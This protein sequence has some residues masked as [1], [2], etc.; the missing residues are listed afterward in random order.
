M[1]AAVQWAKDADYDYVYKVDTDVFMLPSKFIEFLKV[2]A[3][4]KDVDWMGSENKMYRAA[5]A[6]SP[7]AVRV[8]SRAEWH[9]GKCARPDLNRRPYE[10]RR[11]RQR[12]RR[13]RVS[14][15]PQSDVGRLGLLLKHEAELE[16][17][18]YVQHLRGP[19][20]RAHPRH[21]GVPPG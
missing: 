10:G 20:S 1:L 21:A 3:I 11:S 18:R 19:T 17:D 13:A 8:R 4:D 9:F 12:G 16:R 15:Q 6:T 5:P 2:N 7:T 14:P